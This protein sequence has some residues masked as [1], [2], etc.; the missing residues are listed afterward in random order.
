M[1]KKTK[2]DKVK[3]ELDS[4]RHEIFSTKEINELLL[5]EY[6]SPLQPS[7]HCYNR[8]NKQ[9][10]FEEY[11]EKSP[12]IFIYIKRNEYKYVGENHAYTGDVYWKPEGEGKKERIVGKWKDGEYFSLEDKFTDSIIYPDD[13]VGENIIEGAKKQIVVNSY[14]RN[15][16]ARKRCLKEHGYDCKVCGFNFEEK[17]GDIGKN[18]I[19]VHHT[20]PLSEIG[21]EY[22]VD[23]NDLI[24]ICPNCHAMLH[25]KRNPPYTIDELKD[26]INTQVNKRSIKNGKG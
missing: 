26:K 25:K 3:Q 15:P 22:E 20:K 2:L 23:P 8:I 11:F 14:E 21:E 12:S 1:R 7:D 18:F 17:Y 6:E 4:K 9:V 16:D 13:M 24:P 19:H 10:N 5:N